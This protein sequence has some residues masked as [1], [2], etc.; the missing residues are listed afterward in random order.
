MPKTKILYQTK[1]S[2]YGKHL[3]AKTWIQYSGKMIVF[4]RKT[5]PVTLNIKSEIAD[6]FMRDILDKK[7]YLKEIQKPK[8]MQNFQ[9]GFIKE[10]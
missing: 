3:R 8:Y 10:R 4:D 2:I 6:S 7:R 9:N 1:E 5:N